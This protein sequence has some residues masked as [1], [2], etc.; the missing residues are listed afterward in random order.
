MR[1][2]QLCLFFLAFVAWLAPASASTPSGAVGPMLL[3]DTSVGLPSAGYPS[4]TT[5]KIG[6]PGVGSGSSGYSLSGKSQSITTPPGI[7]MLVYF[8]Y[9]NGSPPSGTEITAW[10][11][12]AFTPRAQ[13]VASAIRAYSAANNLSGG[14]YTYRQTLQVQGRPQPMQLFWQVAA[15][16]DGRL[17]TQSPRLVPA[18]LTYLKFLYVPM[19]VAEGLSSGLAYPDA[20]KLTYQLVDKNDLPLTAATQVD[21]AGAYDEPTYSGSGPIPLGCADA[22]GTVTCATDYGVRC[23]I[24]K[25]SYPSCPSSYPDMVTLID[26]LAANGGILDYSRA[27][28]PVVDEYEDP[29]GSGTVVQVPRVAIAIDSRSYARDADVDTNRWMYCPSNG[30]GYNECGI[31]F[32]GTYIA[33]VNR[34]SKSGCGGRYGFTGGNTRIW[35]N[36]GCRADFLVYGTIPSTTGTYS[37][38]GN[39][40]YAL[41]NQTDR[42]RVS[43]D[44]SYAMSGQAV[45][46]A[47]S[48]HEPFAKSAVYASTCVS[49]QPDLII[50]PFATTSIYNWRNDTVNG[51]PSDRY[52]S[53]NGVVCN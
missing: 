7:A 42:Y 22:G 10:A 5:A 6:A 37:E 11:E 25:R 3:V 31:G 35:V 28:S 2:N 52:V 13:A 1:R 19:R 32:T 47:A 17:L 34:H 4:V 8:N 27:L 51:L 43:A 14:V 20:G 39:I 53:V 21:T 29:P 23:L 24:D 26:Q 12:S 36:G 16:A 9:V 48:P 49:L 50:D 38:S 40:G 45:T 33:Q 41:R 15:F 18:E 30:Y 46:T 44:G